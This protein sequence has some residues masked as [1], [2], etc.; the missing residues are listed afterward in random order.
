MSDSTNTELLA[1][2]ALAAFTVDLLVYPLDT[3][4]TRYQSQDY[5]RAFAPSASAKH[6][7]SHVFKGLYQGIGSV[8]FAT[9][10]AAGVFFLTYESA[11]PILGTALP[12]ATPLPVIHALA[13]AGAE[14][15]SC[16][17][18]A[19]AEVV[20]QNAQMLRQSPS[21]PGYSGRST[22]IEALHMVW[23][24]AGGPGRRLWSGYTALAVR[25][26]PFTAMQFPLFEVFRGHLWKRRDRQ[27]DAS[28]PRPTSREDL[29]NKMRARST[30]ADGLRP[31]LIE[32]GLVTG[33]CAAMSGALAALIT[34]PTDVV[35]TRMMLAAGDKPETASSA[36]AADGAVDSRARGGREK[37]NGFEVARSVLRERGIRG[38]FRG[39]LLRGTW[40]AL[41]SGLYLGS[42]EVAKVY[43]KGT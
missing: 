23:R 34:T 38:I 15:A 33:S 18:L 37:M 20:K 30:G 28:D 36:A 4:K 40:T 27:R 5:H 42:Y 26:L 13:S 2:G 43:L 6:V 21:R 19:P 16:A 8:I 11:K 3:I 31:L 25:N 17:V 39:A 22:S 12:S 24:S 10:P 32:T 41:G 35:K 1:A 9:L 14:L 29:Q 7:P